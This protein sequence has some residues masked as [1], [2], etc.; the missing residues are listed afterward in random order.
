MRKVRAEAAARMAVQP[1]ASLPQDELAFSP[2][3]APDQVDLRAVVPPPPLPPPPDRLTV[4]EPRNLLLQLPISASI[5]GGPASAFPPPAVT[6]ARHRRRRSDS[7]A[8]DT[9]FVSSRLDAPMRD[10]QQ[11][12]LSAVQRRRA[13]RLAAVSPTQTPQQQRRGDPFAE[14]RSPVAGEHDV[15]T[16]S[17]VAPPGT[18]PVVEP[19]ASHSV[20]VDSV[21]GWPVRFGLTPLSSGWANDGGSVPATDGPATDPRARRRQFIDI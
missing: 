15:D 2:G 14:L 18:M 13:A 4:G 3:A 1:A 17:N 11:L 8:L 7:E 12:P 10:S 9:L 6:P 16:P 5:P 19:T 21:G 20:G